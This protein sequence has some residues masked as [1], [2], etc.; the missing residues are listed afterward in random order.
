MSIK[1]LFFTAF[2][3]LGLVGCSSTPTNEENGTAET[4]A[5]TE[6]TASNTAEEKNVQVSGAD[7]KG[8]Q[9]G[10]N[11]ANEQA[12][13]EDE[14]AEKIKQLKAAVEGKM[15][16]F[17]FDRSEIKPEYYPVIKA[18]ADYMAADDTVKVEIDGH[19]D[20]R[21]TREYNLALGERRAKSAKNA[22]VALGISPDRITTI[23]Y[24]EE[25]PLDP[26][27]NEEAWAKNR[28]DEFKFSH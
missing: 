20:E 16:H 23:S 10:E 4:G 13:A 21:G 17:D 24:G 8:A 15:I 3:A 18:I 27:H 14:Q 12:T 11:L 28:R 25:R 9:A 19:C 7:A 2:L 22:L 26:R 5:A 6:K 1:H